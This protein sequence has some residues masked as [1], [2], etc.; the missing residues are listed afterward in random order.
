MDINQIREPLTD[1]FQKVSQ[2][3]AI[4]QAI[5]FGSYST[6]TSTEES[7]IDVVVV[8]E[9]FKNLR[10]DKRL[11]ILDEAAAFIRPEI[12]AAGFTRKELER[13][14]KFSIIGQARDWGI[15]FSGQVSKR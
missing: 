6:G 12:V 2:K 1:F 7:D 4:D 13:A 3:I 10:S 15:K 9:D 5:V 14:S 8:S 11:K